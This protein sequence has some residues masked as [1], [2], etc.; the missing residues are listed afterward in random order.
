M[1]FVSRVSFLFC[2]VVSVVAGFGIVVPSALATRHTT[3]SSSSSCRG[4]ALF[5][6][7]IQ[8][9]TVKWFNTQKGFGFITPDDGS[10][11]IFVH[12]TSVQMEGFR[13]LADGE[14]VEFVVETDGTGR[15]KA[16]SVTGPD[17][18]DVQGAPF[19]P[20]NDYNRY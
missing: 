2:L 14:S 8:K 19:Q 17:G 11:D 16:I 15:K 9:G 20:S 6:A 7:N 4:T 12:Q 3:S 10:A 1:S 13:S 5:M 18:A